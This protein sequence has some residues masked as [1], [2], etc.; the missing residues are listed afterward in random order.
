MGIPAKIFPS[1]AGLLLLHTVAAA[2]SPWVYSDN[3]ITPEGTIRITTLGS[4][5]PDVRKEQA[6]AASSTASTAQNSP[7]QPAG[8][9]LSIRTA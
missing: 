8:T 1:L 4:G 5:S 2:G 7:A 9:C 3:A 6:S